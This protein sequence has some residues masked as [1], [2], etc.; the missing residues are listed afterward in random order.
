MSQRAWNTL[1]ISVLLGS[2]GAHCGSDNPSTD[3]T[4]AGANLITTGLP[5][6]KKLSSFDNDDARAACESLSAGVSDL[7]SNTELRRAQCA[8][9]AINKTAK[10]DTAK[11]Q[12]TIDL[13]ECNSVLQQC[14]AD[15][16]SFGLEPIVDGDDCDKAVANTQ[17][18]QCEATVAEYEA[19]MRKIFEQAKQGINNTKCENA[20][21]LIKTDGRPTQPDPDHIAECV[22]FHEK[23]PSVNVDL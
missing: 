8:A 13:A 17:I 20:E 14:Q 2:S 5:A 10:V 9:E 19:C 4:G 15:P 18:K 1:L 3:G 23:C 22:A 6:D 16:A 21:T 11:M 12:V 7:V